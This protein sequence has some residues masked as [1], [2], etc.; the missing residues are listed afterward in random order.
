MVVRATPGTFAS[1]QRMPPIIPVIRTIA[2][3]G[4]MSDAGPLSPSLSR[5]RDSNV[6]S[7]REYAMFQISMILSSAVIIVVYGE[8]APRDGSQVVKDLRGAGGR[9]RRR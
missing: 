7:G 8:K 1:S 3:D 6:E 5:F 9:R 4:F 2:P